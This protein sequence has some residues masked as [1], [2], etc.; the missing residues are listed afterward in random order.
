ML[1]L[2]HLADAADPLM[3]IWGDA[4]ALDGLASALREASQGG[5]A[6][7]LRDAARDL[8]VTVDATETGGGMIELS[9]LTF[10]WLI[11][12]ADGDRFA[13]LVD[14]VSTSSA[15]CHHYLDDTEGRGLTTKVSKGEYPDDFRP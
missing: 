15:P 11:R 12:R 2:A 7:T 1:R 13:S 10:R 4:A 9:P 5:R 3:L 8:Q 14:V 6:L